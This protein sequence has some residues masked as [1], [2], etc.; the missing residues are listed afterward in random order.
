MNRFRFNGRIAGRPLAPGTY[1][2]TLRQRGRTTQLARTLVTIVA[3]GAPVTDRVAPQCA[4]AADAR[5]SGLAGSLEGDTGVAARAS[6]KTDPVAPTT[7]PEAVVDEG[8]A[9]P[10]LPPLQLFDEPDELP[11]ALGLAVLA[12]LLVSLVGILVEVIRHV[13]SSHV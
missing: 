11:I 13:R 6:V 1:L 8:T 9:F 4:V 2:L 3:P 12:L 7:A 10:F 5:G